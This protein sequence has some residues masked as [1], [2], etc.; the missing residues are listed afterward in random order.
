MYNLS[1][2]DTAFST[3]MSVNQVYLLLGRFY[4]H[5]KSPHSFSLLLLFLISSFHLYEFLSHISFHVC[6]EIIWYV[7]VWLFAAVSFIAT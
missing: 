1:P 7:C 5:F 2:V 3:C 6:E 4:R